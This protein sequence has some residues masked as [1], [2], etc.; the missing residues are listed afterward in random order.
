MDV[1][2]LSRLQFAAATVFHFLFVPL[3]LGLVVL[4]AI[5]ETLYVRTG[6]DVYLKMTKFWGKL[7]LINFAIGIVTGITLEFQFGTNWARYSA[8]VG[9]VFGPL[10]AIESTLAFFLESTFIGVWLFGWKRLSPKMHCASIWLVAIATNISAFWILAAGAW[11]RHPVGFVIR[12]GRAELESLLE[13]ITQKYA[14]LSFFHTLTAAYTLAGFF[15]AGISAWHLAR[16]SHTDFFKR[17]FKFGITFG[18]LGALLVSGAGHLNGQIVA[19]TQPSKFAAMESL[20]VGGENLPMNLIQWPDSTQEKNIIEALPI[21]GMLS[22]LAHSPTGTRTPGLKDYVPGDRP[23]VLPVF[24]SFRIMVGLGALLIL[25]AAFGT[26]KMTT[27][28]NY[29]WYLKLLPFA[30]PIPYLAI[31]LGWLVAEVGR[32]PWVVFNIMRTKDAVSTAISSTQVL[33]TLIGFV[34]VYS[35]LGA[36]DFYLLFKF[37]RKGPTAGGMH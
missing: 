24:L 34:V 23:P 7:F 10:L 31:E 29:P 4:V 21:P 25:L 26:W 20:W 11:M 1:V 3:T 37:A 2:L 16:K 28:E 36:V 14:F 27:I 17:S 9:D 8:F 30:I 5:M 33:S 22:L 12:N 6:Q 13:I 15:V 35:L 32:Q 18:L 19:E